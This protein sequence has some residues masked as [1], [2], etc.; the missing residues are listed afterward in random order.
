MY[1]I[2]KVLSGQIY[3]YDFY[4]INLNIL[5]AV[6]DQT[7]KILIGFWLMCQIFMT[8]VVIY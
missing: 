4:V 6:D 1:K 5:K 2:K 3:T 7:F 8:M